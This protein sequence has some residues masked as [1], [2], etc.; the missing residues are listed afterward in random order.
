MD[1]KIHNVII[2]ERRRVSIG[3]VSEVVSFNEDE[4]IFK[5]KGA[6]LTIKGENLHVSELSVETGDAV[7]TGSSID[8]I[9]YSKIDRERTGEGFFRRLLK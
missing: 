2:E 7:V 6:T 8:S 5:V 9:I 1:E 3:A 4:T